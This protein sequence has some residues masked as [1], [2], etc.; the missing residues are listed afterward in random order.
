VLHSPNEKVAA[1]AHF[2]S[3]S[4]INPAQAEDDMLASEANRTRRG[5]STTCMDI[6]MK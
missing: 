5:M 6:T 4:M 1:V 3:I 2:G